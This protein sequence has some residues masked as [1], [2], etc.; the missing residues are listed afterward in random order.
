MNNT[1]PDTAALP[2]RKAQARSPIAEAGIGLL[3][4]VLSGLLGLAPWLAS[5]ARLPLQN[6]WAVQTMPADMP[7]ALRPRRPYE[8]TTILALLTVGGA[9]AGLAVRIW[10]P[11]RRGLATGCAVGGLLLVQAGAAAQALTVLS[12]GLGRGSLA[13]LYFA[14]LL[15]GTITAVAASAAALLLL[16]APS[17]AVAAVGMGLMAVPAVSWLAAAVAYA[18][19]PFNVPVP[20]TLAWRWLPAVLVGLALGWCGLRPQ[21]RIAVWAANLLLLWLLPAAFTAISS[22][23]GTRVIAGDVPEMLAMGRQVLGSALGPA[24]G[25]GYTVTLAL[26]IGL[27]GAGAGE[28]RRRQAKSP[29]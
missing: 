27:A 18:A 24:G 3:V 21:V 23:L 17:R 25:A 16:A 12:N 6:L 10:K 13:T 7:V 8:V 5:G 15:A 29:A 14:G 4:G 28:I 26:A 2:A 20:L 9:L 19:G 1:E 22:V 11:G